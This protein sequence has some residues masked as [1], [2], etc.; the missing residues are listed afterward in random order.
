[1]LGIR[2]DGRQPEVDE[3]RED[4][5]DGGLL[6]VSYVSTRTTLVFPSSHLPM[7]NLICYFKTDVMDC[8]DVAPELVQVRDSRAHTDF[9]PGSYQLDRLDKRSL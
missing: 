6:T 1:M 4:A 8:P 2:R 5:A 9:T 7:L 3:T